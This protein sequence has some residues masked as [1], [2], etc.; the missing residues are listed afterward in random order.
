MSEQ[1]FVAAGRADAGDDADLYDRVA[2]LWQSYL[3]MKRYWDTK[4]S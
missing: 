1:E 3:G 2:P 4:R